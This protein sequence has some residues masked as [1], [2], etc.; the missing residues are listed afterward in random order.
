MCEKL[1]YCAIQIDPCI[2]DR[3]DMI[4]E[5]YGNKTLASCCG[6]GV[7]PTTIVYID[8]RINIVYVKFWKGKSYTGEI[9]IEKKKGNR[10]YK[11]DKITKLYYIPEVQ[12]YLKNNIQNK[13]GETK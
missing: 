6:H 4:N 2:R 8:R 5:L 13:I 1:R 12:E 9:V 11:K 7:Y 10:Y 3:V